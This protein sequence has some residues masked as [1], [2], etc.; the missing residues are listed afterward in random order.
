MPVIPQFTHTSVLP[1]PAA[2]SV[3]PGAFAAV[4]E[5]QG[6]AAQQAGSGIV[7]GARSISQQAKAQAAVELRAD[8]VLK[9]LK[10]DRGL[11]ADAQ[12]YAD[13]MA[14]RQDYKN[15]D[16]DTAA[17][18]QSLKNKYLEEAGG[19]KVLQAAFARKFNQ[20]SVQLTHTARVK[21]FDV[22]S[23]QALGAFSE[24]YDES[25]KES[26]GE[27]NPAH[28][29]LIKKNVEIG[30][31]SMVAAGYM[32]PVQENVLIDKFTNSA[33][34]LRADQLI[35]ANPYTA[36]KILKSDE[37]KSFDPGTRQKKIE[38][39]KLRQK[40]LETSTLVAAKYHDQQIK[41]Q[42]KEIHDSEE[43]ALGEEYIKGNFDQIL[44]LLMHSKELSGTE[45]KNWTVLANKAVSMKDPFKTSNYDFFGK[46][47]TKAVDGG[48]INPDAI[49]PIPGKLSRSDAEIVRKIAKRSLDP[50]EKVVTTLTK[51]ARQTI[52]EQIKKG[53]SIF[54]F[55]PD[56]SENSYRALVALTQELDREPDLQ[57]R[58]DMLTPGSK[59]YVVG[60]II[61]PFKKNTNDLTNAANLVGILNTLS[62]VEPTKH[63][64]TNFRHNSTTGET[65]GLDSETGKWVTVPSK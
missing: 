14:H 9:S 42:K 23:K 65:I 43:R 46:Q 19:D 52:K 34:N 5:A 18:L 11:A 21:K 17:Q 33:D 38:A 26:A 45:L 49:I 44:P 50:K 13:S 24:Q 36:E 63:K 56:T 31:A 60:K 53:S 61:A 51:D 2:P 29:E 4:S 54:G 41:K 28:R 20:V 37:F 30:A 25:L 10:I 8:R 1:V 7:S 62:G 12:T 27:V 59:S 39:A 15:F 58:I 55:S 22:M 64:L 47:I 35:D 6:T 48:F 16:T 40:Q 57:K 3:S 32:T